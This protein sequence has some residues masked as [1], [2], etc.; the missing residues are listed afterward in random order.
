MLNCTTGKKQFDFKEDAEVHAAEIR[1]KSSKNIERLHVF[2]CP[3]CWK[4][5]VGKSQVKLTSN[6][7]KHKK[8]GR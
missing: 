2:Q 7:R 6:Q 4:W 5:H 1:K 3:Y 8:F